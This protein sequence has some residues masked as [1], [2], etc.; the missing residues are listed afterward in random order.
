MKRWL[1]GIL[2]LSSCG[3][4]SPFDEDYWPPAPDI[5]RETQGGDNSNLRYRG[6]FTGT[7]NEFSSV[8]GSVAIN[9]TDTEAQI[10]VS[11]SNVPDYL[12]FS[13]YLVTD[14]P[15]SDFDQAPTDLPVDPA[16]KRLEFDEE[17]AKQSV[18]KGANPDL[19]LDNRNLI[20]Y[21][22]I[23]DVTNPTVSTRAIAMACATLQQEGTND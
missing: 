20:I 16:S 3:D 23:Q 8:Q 21:G 1:L 12:N 14:Q 6:T 10:R 11:L 5:E 18:L 7:S 15:C 4:N 17:G 19:N 13:Q 22:V 9:T 2:F